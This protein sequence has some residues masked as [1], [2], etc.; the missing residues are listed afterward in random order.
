MKATGP[1]G[2]IDTSDLEDLSLDTEVDTDPD[3]LIGTFR[4]RSVIASSVLSSASQRNLGQA[5]SDSLPVDSPLADTFSVRRSPKAPT[6]Y[7]GDTGIEMKAGKGA[8]DFTEHKRNAGKYT[9]VAFLNSGSGGGVG[10]LILKDMQ[11]LLGQEFVFDLRKCGRGNMPS[12]NLLPYAKDPLVRV[13]AC[14][15]DGTMGWILSSLDEVWKQILGDT[16]PLEESPFK[17]HLPLAMMPLGTGNDLSRSFG[18]GPTFSNSMRKQ[19]MIDKVVQATP[20][21]LDRWRAVVVPFKSLSTDARKWVPAMLGEK[22]RNR[23]E[24]IRA[25]QTVFTAEEEES[26]SDRGVRNEGGAGG[27]KVEDDSDAVSTR[28][29]SCSVVSGVDD[30]APTAQSFDGVFCNYF[31]IGLDARVAFSFHKEREEHPERFTSPLKNK[32]KYIQKGIS[33]GGLLSFTTASL[34]KKLNG[35]VRVMVEDVDGELREIPMPAH[36]RGVALLNIQS[37]GG[38]NRFANGGSYNDGLIE[39]IF[40]THPIGMGICAGMGPILPFLRFK[41]RSRTSRVCIRIDEPYHCQVDGEPW[42]QS[43]GVFQISYFGR[44]P[45]LRNGGGCCK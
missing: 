31:S 25:L 12:D 26:D 23:T 10:K 32:M 6:L 45:V 18:W 1:N 22:M 33:V 44:S 11:T 8:S 21:P 36:C 29:A 5:I 17:G 15:G 7:D 20:Q 24:S 41:V 14:G 13:L 34:P 3:L 4:R 28:S 30:L 2:G 37:Y 40:F 27:A 42:M 9:V 16:Q 38:G 19:G 39:V 35:K 43:A